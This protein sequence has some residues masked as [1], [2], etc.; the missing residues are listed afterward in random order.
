MKTKYTLHIITNG[1]EEVQ[2]IKLAA[3][4][5]KQYF[6]VVITSERA[7]IK[8]PNPKIFNFALSQAKTTEKE[9]IYIGDDLEVD[10]IGCQNCEI[11]GVY[12]NPE[13]ILHSEK[14]SFEIS[15]LSQLQEIF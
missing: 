7:G 4:D 5:L 15:C 10:I 11:K 1:F 6:D 8:K 9:S 13:K 3:A 12:F 14:P 2:H